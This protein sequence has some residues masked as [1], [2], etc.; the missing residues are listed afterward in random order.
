MSKEEKIKTDIFN[1]FSVDKEYFQLSN[2]NA[3][4]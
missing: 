2:D 4:I 3:I 1:S